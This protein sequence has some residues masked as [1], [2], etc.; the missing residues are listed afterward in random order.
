MRLQRW[1]KVTHRRGMLL[2]RRQ[3]WLLVVNRRRR[4]ML[5]GWFREWKLLLLLLGVVVRTQRYPTQLVVLEG[6]FLVWVR[7]RC[8]GVEWLLWRRDL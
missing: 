5:L 7:H 6:G 2:R 4:G 8:G 3:R 1:K